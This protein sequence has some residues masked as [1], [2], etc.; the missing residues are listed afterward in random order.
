MPPVF[1]SVLTL[2]RARTVPLASRTY[3]ER[4]LSAFS[5]TLFSVVSS[6]TELN[7]TGLVSQIYEDKAALVADSL[8]ESAYNDFAHFQR[9]FAA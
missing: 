6:K 4:T 1:I 7:D 3:S 2:S 9:N 8:C 5:N